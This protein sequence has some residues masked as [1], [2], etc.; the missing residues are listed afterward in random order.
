MA[1]TIRKTRKNR[2]IGRLR[3]GDLTKYGYSLKFSAKKR[4]AALNRSI[5]AY[6]KGTLIKKLNALHV[7]NKYNHPEYSKK[8]YDDMRYVMK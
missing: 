6:G 7:F 4:H 3:S 2:P 1:R 8:A 5:K